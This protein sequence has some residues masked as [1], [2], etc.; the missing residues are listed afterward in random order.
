MDVRDALRRALTL[1]DVDRQ[2]DALQRE[3][4][5]LMR[6]AH[7]AE[8]VRD[9]QARRTQRERLEAELAEI[10]RQQRL[11]ELERQSVTVER[12]RD[13]TRL[14]GGQVRATRDL[15][16]LQR[17][18]EG[19]ERRI[20]ELE[21][22]ILEAMDRVVALRAK[23]EIAAQRQ[24]TVEADLRRHKR[25]KSDRLQVLEVQM[26][27]LVAQRNQR[28]QEVDPAVLREYERLRGGPDGI[29][30][31]AV[32]AGSCGACG[33]GLSNLLQSRVREGSRLVNCENCGRLL[34]AE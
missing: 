26:P 7:Q 21:T 32:V 33:V 17:N 5:E 25:A 18:V 30:V 31:A 1:Q 19:A 15:E 22:A 11:A 8:L 16:G 28:A 9:L 10:E 23:V 14:Y 27:T 3:R 13:R 6:D 12:D 2:L 20:D 4:Q 29:A 34:V 24:A